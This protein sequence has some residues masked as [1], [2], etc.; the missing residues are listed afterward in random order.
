MAAKTLVR[1]K[2]MKGAPTPSPSRHAPSFNR[3][4]RGLIEG[5]RLLTDRLAKFLEVLEDEEDHRLI[6]EAKKRNGNKPLISWEDAKKR[7]GLD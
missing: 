5:H 4:L 3:E 1:Q 7:L 6:Q 2:K